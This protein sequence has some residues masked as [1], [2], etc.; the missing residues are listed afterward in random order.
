M[1]AHA[2]RLRRR[3]AWMVALLVLWLPL[4]ARPDALAEPPAPW[5]ERLEP[6]AVPDLAGAEPAARAAMGEQ[7]QA[8]AA[9]VGGAGAAAAEVAEAYGR[10]GALYQVHGLITLAE[11]A[12]AN[13]IALQPERF[14]WAYYAARLAAGAGRHETALERYADARR[15]RPDYPPLRL[16]EGESLL[17]LG[18]LAE[19]GAALEAAAAAPGLAARALYHLAQIDLL[20]HRPEAAAERLRRVLELAPEADGVHYPLARALRAMG[21]D[22]GARRHMAARGRRLPAVDDPLA[23][24]LAALDTGARRHFAAGLKAS[25]ERDYEAAADAFAAGLAI[26]PANPHARVSLAR[27]LYLAGRPD[28]ARAELDAALAAAPEHTLALF[29]KGLLLEESGEGAAAEA[30]YRRVLEARPGHYGAH[31][32]LAN[33]RYAAGDF[34]AAARHYR[35]ALEANPRIPPA[36][37]HELLAL[38]QAGMTDATVKSR[39]E[40]AV[41]AH[42]HQPELR[43]ALIRLLVLSPDAGVRDPERARRMVNALV[44]EAFLPP[45]V[46]LQALVA[47][48]VGAFDQAVELQE[49][50][51]PALLWSEAGVHD[52][53]TA[54]LEVYQAGRLPAERWYDDPL[55]LAPPANAAAPMM[56][57]YPAPVPY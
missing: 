17:E 28:A 30:L 37:L 5:A 45:F 34:D 27:A 25:R 56:R 42:P 39:L 14:R 54:A 53:A 16:R 23:A 38:R 6:V 51:L 43:Y 46:A 50:V 24:E 55:L 26:E 7:R 57:E 13:A 8:A 10:L 48:A 41:A 22:A 52:R 19:A 18:R 4:T 9:L 31:Y 32:C 29:L 2:P 44:R 47:A 11:S 40:A 12:Y 3:P 35:A 21:D 1:V 33:R 49:Q 15:L 20:Q 36:R